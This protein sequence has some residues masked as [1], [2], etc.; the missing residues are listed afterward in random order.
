MD[1]ERHKIVLAEGMR[2]AY[3]D[4]FQLNNKANEKDGAW[5]KNKLKM[6][7]QGKKSDAVISKMAVTFTALC[8]EADFSTPATAPKETKVETP[9][10]QPPPALPGKEQPQGQAKEHRF[11]LAYNIHIEL[12][13][14]RDQAVYDA[15]FKSLR[16]NLL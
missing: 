15:I 8:K 3:A 5:V 6:L 9:A 11:A 7:T 14:V 1:D 16:E 2:R 4:L 12:P 13:A 10:E